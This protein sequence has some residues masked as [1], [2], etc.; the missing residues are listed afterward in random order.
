MPTRSSS[1][2]SSPRGSASAGSS[3]SSPARTQGVL[4]RRSD[5][6]ARLR[7]RSDQARGGRDPGG[8]AG[9]AIASPPELDRRNAGDRGASYGPFE[10]IDYSLDE[11]VK[12]IAGATD[13][14]VAAGAPDPVAFRSG[15]YSAS[16]DTLAALAELGFRYDSS[17]NGSEHPWPSAI[18]L[19]ARQI[20]PIE[21]R[22][23]IEVP[24]T[25]IEDQKGHLR[26]FQICA[27]SAAEMKA[28][29]DH[30]AREGHAA[31]TVV[32]PQLR[33]RQSRGH[34]A[35]CSACP[36]LRGA[37]AAA[38]QTP[39]GAGDHAFR[40]S[41]G[42]ALDQPRIVRSGPAC[43]APG[44]ARPSSS[45]PTWSRSARHDDAHPAAACAAQ[46]RDRRAHVARGPALAGTGAADAGGGA[47]G[48]A[49]GAAAAGSR[50]R[51]AI[52]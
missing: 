5:A 38:R 13:M 15:S 37:C 42:A 40:R 48:P 22:G 41:A 33:A 45:G 27:L 36:P 26:H 43:C 32:G 51:T 52:R 18:G 8:G 21:H 31:V 25:L 46:V 19:G 34:A 17:H 28:A 2:R 20:A 10:L 6:G 4:L 50:R 14:L 47:R 9:G 30:A 23:M 16:D 24:V 12:L 29:L 35:Q 1:A 44:C 3:I 7:P 49:A 39:R 11:Q